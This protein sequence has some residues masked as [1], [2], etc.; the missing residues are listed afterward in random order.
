MSWLN[1]G[2]IA[3]ATGE[4]VILGRDGADF[5]AVLPGWSLLVDGSDHQY[6]ILR[7]E[8]RD[9]S[10]VS[11]L[12]LARP[13]DGP[14]VNGVGYTVIPNS[15]GLIEAT[16]TLAK[17]G[18][19]VQGAADLLHDF[20]TAAGPIP[21]VDAQGQ[22]RQLKTLPQLERETD[23]VIGGI[24]VYQAQLGDLS[25][26]VAATSADRTAV[27]ADRT[28]V[29]ADRAAVALA[30]ASVQ[31]DV[32]AAGTAAASAQTAKTGAESAQAAAQT[33][34]TGAEAAKTGAE[35]AQAAAQTA[36][37]G[38]EAAKTG[39]E[40]AQAA[41]TTARSGAES[42]KT[43]AD[44]AQAAAQAA[45]TAAETAQATAAVAKTA[46]E[47][48][49]A[50]AES[51]KTA[52]ETA[53]AGAQTAQA[54]AETAQGGAQAAKSGAE[55]ARDQAQAYAL[56]AE[57]TPIPGLGVYSAL[58][59]ARRAEYWAGQAQAAANV[60]PATE[61]AAGLI[62]LAT[63]A[64]TVSGTDALRAV[65][66]A[67]LQAKI[68]ALIQAA[69]GALD[70]LNELAAAL[71]NDP[72]FAATMSAALA[73]KAPLAHDHDAAGVLR[74]RGSVASAALDTATAAG[75]YRV[76]YNGQH[77]RTLLV[78]DAPGTTGVV[79]VESAY[80][81]ESRWR[82]RTDNVSWS[83]W[84]EAWHSG[85]FDP[86]SKA[87]TAHGHG[88]A[89]VAGLAEALAGKAPTGHGHALAEIAGLV[90]AL[91]A[92]LDASAHTWGALAGK[93]ASFPP[94]AHTHTAAEVSGVP[95]ARKAAL[96]AVAGL[97]ELYS[98]MQLGA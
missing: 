12:T 92:K 59:Y 25:T 38:A 10:G 48:A 86:A 52:A 41:A 60:G 89:E 90:A 95:D 88:L 2:K 22:N 23:A 5:A 11:R 82:N 73:G 80:S 17:Y 34:K 69:P 68:D 53:K 77:Q 37:A 29:A 40:L 54:A 39:V 44:S 19:M 28:A 66:P 21:Y 26:V 85:N 15:G 56:T 57:N 87:A 71:G 98:L 72:N 45:K 47:T 97:S 9:G 20:A 27:A 91:A 65:T 43:G 4:L 6:E 67:G 1:V 75:Y 36:Q 14:S 83:A 64:E 63:A 30:K 61:A 84:R 35:L 42:A 93:P 13:Y 50:G 94:S 70:T 49:Q 96:Y 79:Q 7:G 8:G 24:R 32:A 33:A 74:Y 78:F 51:A 81:G 55:V 16:A 31:E 46:A 76:D 58:H 18:G 3:V 62:E